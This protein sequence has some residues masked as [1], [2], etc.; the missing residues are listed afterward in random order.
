M[1]RKT[2]DITSLNSKLQ[3]LLAVRGEDEPS[4]EG[5]ADCVCRKPRR[6]AALMV[7]AGIDAGQARCVEPS[8]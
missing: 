3:R 6:Q 8:A 4:G 7:P 5:A 1:E 2:R